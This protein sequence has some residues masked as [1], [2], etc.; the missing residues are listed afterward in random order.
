MDMLKN[1]GSVLNQNSKFTWF[2]LEFY[3]P[4]R[5]E[6]QSQNKR[7]L[8]QIRKG[9]VVPKIYDPIAI[10]SAIIPA[11]TKT[12]LPENSD[13][14][15]NFPTP[16]FAIGRSTIVP[17]NFKRLEQDSN[18]PSKITKDNH[19]WILIRSLLNHSYTTILFI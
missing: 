11:V 8:P 7:P 19:F 10:A 14:L 13:K 12:I 2:I 6:T 1:S 17:T 16:H 3:Y 15:N 9:I 5:V 18:I 4:S